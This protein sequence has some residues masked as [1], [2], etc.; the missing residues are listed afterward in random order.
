[1][2]NSSI[3]NIFCDDIDSDWHKFMS[4]L[5]SPEAMYAFTML[6]GIHVPCPHV[7]VDV[8]DDEIMFEWPTDK[9]Y[10]VIS[11]SHSVYKSVDWCHHDF[12]LNRITSGSGFDDKVISLLKTIFDHQVV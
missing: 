1:M 2:K 11:V 8:D 4:T 6:N 9:H 10:V 7:T 5:K 12:D 3:N